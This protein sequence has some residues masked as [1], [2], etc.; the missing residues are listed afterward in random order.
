MTVK[1]RYKKPDQDTSQ[2]LSFPVLQDSYIPF[3][4]ASADFKFATSVVELGLLLR[5]SE[6]KGKSSYEHVLKIAKKFKGLDKEG[7]RADFIRLA[8]I[9]EILVK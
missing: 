7:Y 3:N 6:F 4:K 1:I 8:E 9:C 2:L 5:D